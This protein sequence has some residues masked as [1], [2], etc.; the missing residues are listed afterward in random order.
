MS[1]TTTDHR[2]ATA[3]RNVEAILDAVEALLA[4]G[5][6]ASTSA[7]AA[8]AGVSRV[9][10]YAHFATREALLEAVVERVVRRATTAIAAAEIGTGPP[11]EA[12][13]RLVAAAW[14]ELERNRV[15]ANAASEE[16]SPAAMT[17]S[18]E[19]LYEPIAALVRRGQDAGAFR[20]DLPAG[21][22]VASYF[23][24]MHACGEE[25]RAGRLPEGDAVRTLQT[26]LRGIVE[27]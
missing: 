19:A 10:V 3:E 7:V 15:V 16:L 2:R 8:Q 9:T 5:A 24:L 11:L 21:W 23:A 1:D 12:L 20:G 6:A 22:L 17:R 18:H 27:R 13:E 14:G 25:V 4:R 26:T